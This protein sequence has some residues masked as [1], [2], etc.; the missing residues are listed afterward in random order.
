MAGPG[1]G[2]K[3]EWFQHPAEFP[4]FCD[5][6]AYIEKAHWRHWGTARARASATMNEAALNGHN[7][8]G[9]APRRHSPVR[10]VASR[11]K[12]C[13][14]RH[15][16]THIVIHFDKPMNGV[17]KTEADGLLPHCSAN[18][19][20]A[21]PSPASTAEFRT[22]PGGNFVACAMYAGGRAETGRV[23]C[24]GNPRAMEGE[25]PLVQLAKLQADGRVST[26]SQPE[27]AGDHSCE[28]GNFGDPIPTYAP[29]KHVRVGPFV[30]KV[31]AS[32]VECTVATTGKGFL[33]TPTEATSMG[34]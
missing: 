24:Q 8:V 26:C 15:A 21:H 18:H 7:S 3:V 6:T 28:L 2:A 11:I 13:G 34:G 9:T 22:R 17:K 16:Y 5:G 31:L 14:G 29:G 33:I 1:C 10:I 20:P 30:C 23:V 19:A 12:T 25:V 27:A 32:G 4:F